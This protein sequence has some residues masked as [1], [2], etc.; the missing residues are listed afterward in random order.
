MSS[1]IYLVVG[2]SRGIGQELITQLS[3]DA[4]NHVLATVRKS[5]DFGKPNVETLI[6][7]QTNSE[8]VRAAASKVKEV[9]TLILNAA[10]GED[11][12]LT[13]TSE[14]RLQQYL[15]TNVVGVHR[16]I[17]AFLPALK[18]RQTRKIIIISSFSGS[19]EL[20]IGADFGFS[21]PY[22]VTKA[23]NNMQ[24]VQYH[25]ELHKDGFTIVPIH[26]G[27]VSHG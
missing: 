9:D 17:S 12:K 7:D 3:Q 27:W 18:A 2:A 19:C 22:S 24:V 11:E 20:Q 8:S 26:P 23:A 15:N 25:N 16:V 4:S 14:E 1:K 10:I 13:T 6:L 21:G 5:V